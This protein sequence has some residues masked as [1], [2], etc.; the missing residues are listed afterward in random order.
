MLIIN[1]PFRLEK[2]FK[3]AQQITKSILQNTKNGICKMYFQ[4]LKYYYQYDAKYYP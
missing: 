2:L 4:Y 3:E 1:P